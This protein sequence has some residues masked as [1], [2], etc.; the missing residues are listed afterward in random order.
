MSSDVNRSQSSTTPDHVRLK[1]LFDAALGHPP[2]KRASFLHE[3]CGANT[4]L[5][6]EVDALL[7]AHE[8]AATF[9]NTQPISDSPAASATRATASGHAFEAG[10]RVGRYEVVELIG[11]GAMGEVYRARD[12]H[13]GREVAVKVLPA[14]L[15]ADPDRVR[16]FEQE[17]RTVG[18][19]NHP[20]IVAL[21]DVGCM[22][23]A[24]GEGE[25]DGPPFLVTELLHGKT[26]RSRLHVGRVASSD[27]LDWG[28]QMARGLAAAHA[29]GIVHRDLK[30][31]NVFITSDGHVKLLDFGIAKLARTDATELATRTALTEAGMVLGTVGYMAPEQ[32]RGQAVDH[33]ADIFAF[34]AILYEL[35]TGRRAF[36]RNS[37]ID[38]LS[39]ILHTDVSDMSPSVDTLPPAVARVV[40]RCLAKQPDDRFQS[41]AEIVE[42]LIGGATS[43]PRRRIRFVAAVML[44]LVLACAAWMVARRGS[45]SRPGSVDR[46]ASDE[47]VVLAVVPFD[48]IAE[49]PS[50]K[51]FADGVTEEITAQLSR[52]PRLRVMSRAAVARYADSPASLPRLYSELGVRRVVMGTVRLAGDRARVSAQLVDAANDQT[53]W[54]DQYDRRLQDILAV[55]SD[56]ATRVAAALQQQTGLIGEVRVAQ[57]VA[58]DVTAYELYL[59]ARK[60]PATNPEKN[61]AAIELLRD[62]IRR[63]PH[64]ALAQAELA[65]RLGF[66]GGFKEPHYLDQALQAARRAVEI[67]PNEARAHFAL[68]DVYGWRGL[69][70]E[71]RLSFF[72]AAELDPNLAEALADLSITEAAQGRYDQAVYW[73]RR[74]FQLAPNVSFS[75]YHVGLALLTLADDETTEKWLLEAERR[76]PR[77]QR[78]HLLLENLYLVG[79]RREEALK[80]LQHAVA[81]DPGNQEGQ[82]A[83]VEFEVMTGAPEALDHVKALFEQSPTGRTQQ[84]LPETF[85]TMYGSLLAQR[86]DPAAAM[87]LD[88]ALTSAQQE[89]RNGNEDPG[90]RMEIAAIYALREDRSH[91]LEWMNAAYD[92][93]W[94][95]YRETARDPMLA[96][97]KDDPQFQA[98]LGKMKADVAMMRNRIDV[99]ANPTMPSP[100]AVA[101]NLPT[102]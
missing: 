1:A 74:A 47:P 16:R 81:I 15:A 12:P 26:L 83:V 84:M 69:L 39:A 79:D 29:R 101:R 57:P 55:Q 54:S 6:R 34:G 73:A 97:L 99:T 20:N 82:A 58:A 17:A 87:L 71:S 44:T 33:R 32:V 28:M 95:W 18:G 61:I 94:R 51:Y 14:S 38:T 46:S 100:E 67:D 92:G 8:K 36:E 43:L 80:R 102:R 27:A 49:D 65:R 52:L 62:A 66:L 77:Y 90:V 72:R 23:G 42:A 68:G 64:F 25:C 35:F 76:V 91:A 41:A 86:H 9:L 98:I 2:S 24:G 59:R 63:D 75:Y 4:A 37:S 30:P 70:A 19:L 31:E 78:I 22:A 7:A 96:S 40:R 56:I 13:I 45:S 50:R 85:R 60:L 21:Y 88:A 53:L 5:R 48:S 11:A 3:V 10:F 93:G 89:L